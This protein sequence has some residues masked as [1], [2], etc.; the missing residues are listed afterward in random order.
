MLTYH[1]TASPQKLNAISIKRVLDK[2]GLKFTA[3]G[4]YFQMPCPIHGGDNPHGCIIKQEDGRW[5]CNTHKCHEK[6]GGE[7]SGFCRGVLKDNYTDEYNFHSFKKYEADE[8]ETFIKSFA[9]P[10]TKEIRVERSLVLKHLQIPSIQFL[11]RGFSAEILK[12]Y[13]VRIL[14]LPV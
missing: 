13:D 1:S 11:K 8:K 12:K 4:R 10:V 5:W 14:S 6:F 7:F 2:F 3:N 9:K